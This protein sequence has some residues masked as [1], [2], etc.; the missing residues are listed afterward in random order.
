MTDLIRDAL[1]S[2]VWQFAYRR[3]ENGFPVLATGGLSALEEAFAALG[4][5]D[6]AHVVD[7]ECACDV[8]GCPEWSTGGAYWG[9]DNHLRLCHKHLGQAIVKLPRPPLK[10]RA[11]ERQAKK[12]KEPCKACKGRGV[13]IIEEDQ[14]SGD[15]HSVV[16]ME[17]GDCDI[18]GGT[19]KAYARP[20][21]D[22]TRPNRASGGK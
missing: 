4:W 6:D 5:E 12:A 18:C 17:T 16:G 14:Y 11:L 3:A 19:G 21:Q 8:G 20:E 7:E 22:G 9:D 1:E 10:A 2:M 15:P 13:K